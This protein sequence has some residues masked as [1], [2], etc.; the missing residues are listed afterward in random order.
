MVCTVPAALHPCSPKVENLRGGAGDEADHRPDG[1]GN[2]LHAGNEALQ[3]R[4]D[5]GPRVGQRCRGI[6]VLGRRDALNGR[7]DGGLDNVEI[8]AVLGADEGK[9]RI[10]LTEEEFLALPPY[11]IGE[12]PEPSG[13]WAPAPAWVAEDVIMRGSSLLG[14]AVYEPPTPF[15]PGGDCGI[16]P[17]RTGAPVFPWHSRSS[18]ASRPT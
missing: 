13:G 6:A 15:A 10:S 9:V 12:Q 18:S 7:Q 14:G 8:G 1:V 11:V 4:P 2:A 17:T 16:A 5:V 3:A